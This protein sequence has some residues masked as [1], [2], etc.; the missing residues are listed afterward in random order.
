VKLRAYV[1]QHGDFREP[2]SA[3]LEV[4]DTPIRIPLSELF[5]DLD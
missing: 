2:E 5:A 1:C 3:I 4:A